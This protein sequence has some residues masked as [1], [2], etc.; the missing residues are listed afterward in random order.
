MVSP[1]TRILPKGRTGLR[2]E[3]MQMAQMF[4]SWCTYYP[5]DASAWLKRSAEEQRV[6]LE[7]GDEETT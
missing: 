2:A 7:G 3:T 5:E 1:S 4:L 6:V